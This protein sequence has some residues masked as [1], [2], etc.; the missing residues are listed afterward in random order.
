MV[1]P[2]ENRGSLAQLMHWLKIS[3]SQPIDDSP[4]LGVSWMLLPPYDIP[5][6]AVVSG[7]LVENQGDQDATEVFIK[8]RYEGER[9]ITHMEVVSDDPYEIEGGSPRDSFV[10][11]QIPLLHAGGK[12]V[13]Y[14]AGHNVQM[15]V[16][17]VYVAGYSASPSADTRH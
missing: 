2:Q 15:P 16:I 9:F 17:N 14:V 3:D 4:A 6:M 5:G 10:N 1:K 7:V 8:L 13:I 12:L 11:I